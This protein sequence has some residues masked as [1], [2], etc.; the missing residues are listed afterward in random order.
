M[1]AIL[2]EDPP[3]LAQTNR[4]VPPSLDRLI[5][6]CLEKSPEQRFQSIRDLAFNL[7]A[8]SPDSTMSR[9]APT[10]AAAGGR[11]HLRRLMVA[12]LVLAA[13]TGAFVWGRGT[14]ATSSPAFKRLTFRRGTILSAKF[15]P[16]GQTIVYG[17]AWQGAPA[18]LFTTRLES[19][20]ARPLGLTGA[21]ILS[22]SS[23]GEMALRLRG[24]TL[25]RAPLAGGAPREM[26]ENVATAAWAPDG[27]SLAIVRTVANR[28]RLE[29]PAEKV[30]YE[31]AGL[32]NHVSVSANGDLVALSES[33]PGIGSLTSVLVVGLDGTKRTLSEGWR[34][35]QGV[36]WSRQGN[37]VW[38]AASKTSIGGGRLFAVTLD[39]TLRELA[40]VPGSLALHDISR[41]GRVLVHRSDV[42][43]E[44]R[45]L[46][47]GETTERDL[48]WSDFNGL[49]DLSPDGRT[50]IITE[51]GEAGFHTFLRRTD[52]TAAVQLGDGGAF[53][54]SPDGKW[55]I[56]QPLD[57]PRLAIVPTGPGEAKPIVHQRFDSYL[58][59]NWFPDGKRILFVASEVGHGLRPYVQDLS[60]GA[61]RAIA[62]EGTTMKTGSSAISPDGTLLALIGADRR[63]ALYSTAGDSAPRALPALGPGD[64]P[65]R[66]SE[67]G[68]FLFV[69][70]GDR[71]PAAIHR[72][73]LASGM[74]EPWKEVGPTDPA[75][76]TG[77]GHVLVTPDGR[78]YAYNY[79]RALSDLYLVEGLK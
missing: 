4:S 6:R 3:E 48:S 42:R 20:E 74:K 36:A 41:D 37:E 18:E 39:G 5:R 21:T 75:G 40:P 78:S 53:A 23:T 51:D 13:V 49:S 7:E 9:A 35:V 52:G 54:L 73:D 19:T 77:V 25:A 62:P 26:V 79:M 28:R 61:P 15:A 46:A 67:D 43:L 24:G 60:G 38:F 27:R 1:S 16:D 56:S 22:I 30:L 31:T 10:L 14:S 63:V 76:V 66:W 12:L 2:K 8:L 65:S 44:A 11:A 29:F 17:A 71:L 70:R 33:T 32:L 58:W 68:R 50:I 59:A 57:P 64:L 69:F 72:L 45:G 55:I 34:T 47:P